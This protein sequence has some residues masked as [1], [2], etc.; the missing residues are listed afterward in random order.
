MH[1]ANRLTHLAIAVMSI[2]QFLAYSPIITPPH[3]GAGV[4]VLSGS[5]EY[6]WAYALLWGLSALAS[7]YGA[8]RGV[9]KWSVLLYIFLCL[10]WSGGYAGAWVLSH[11]ASD[12]FM[13]ACTYLSIAL[14]FTA[15]YR[16]IIILE[17][18]YVEVVTSAIKTVGGGDE[19][20]RA[21]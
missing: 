7:L 6:L 13:T 3:E 1:T 14:G 15:V 21:F 8:I 18:K 2:K 20:G 5:G 9:G 16:Y 10:C 4:M 12:D 19:P 11:F 17:D